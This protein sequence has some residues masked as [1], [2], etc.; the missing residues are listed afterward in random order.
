MI[1]FDIETGALPLNRLKEICDPF[2]PGSLGSHPGEFDPKSVKLGN[3]KDQAKIDQKIEDCRLKHLEAVAE[4]ERK[5]KTG[6]SDYWANIEGTAAFSAMKA[7]VLAIG[8]FGKQSQIDHQSEGRTEADVLTQF[9]AMYKKCRAQPRKMV[10]FNTREFDLPFLMQRS[11]INQV[12]VPASVLNGRY[13]DNVFVDLRDIWRAGAMR[14]E[15]S[16]DSISRAFGIGKKPDGTT[17]ADFGRL[18]R[19]PEQRH[20]AIEYLAND[21]VMTKAMAERMGVS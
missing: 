10:G 18:F 9:W 8:Y 11:W 3:I 1:V 5:A 14:Q 7:E 20:L 19:D 12:D 6:E 17:G 21:L 16:L 13:L 15:G 2:D 4:Y